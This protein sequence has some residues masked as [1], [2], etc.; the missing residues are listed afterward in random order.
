M[1]TEGFSNREIAQAL[2]VTRKTVEK[3]LGA[4]YAKLGISTREELSAKLGEP[5]A[6]HQHE[7][8]RV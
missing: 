8:A 7:P 4:A 2:F 3:H 6:E 5:R 1:A